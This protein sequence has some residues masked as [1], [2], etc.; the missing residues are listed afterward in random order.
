MAAVQSALPPQRRAEVPV[1]H[2]RPA[3]R[4]RAVAA[5]QSALPA[6]RA[7]LHGT[8]R[9]LFS[10][11]RHSAPPAQRRAE[12]TN[13]TWLCN[14]LHAQ[15]HGSKRFLLSPPAAARRM[16]LFP[17]VHGSMRHSGLDFLGAAATNSLCR[18]GC[19]FLRRCVSVCVCLWVC[20]CLCVCGC[21]FV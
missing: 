1:Q 5:F 11:L 8:T 4:N 21:L 9:F 7:K 13:A 15:L 18:T 2:P 6:Q 20:V 14:P 17:R 19:V 16:E 12:S 10:R 3:A